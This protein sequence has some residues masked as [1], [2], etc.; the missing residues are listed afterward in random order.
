MISFTHLYPQ[1]RSEYESGKNIYQIA[2]IYKAWPETVRRGIHKAGGVT[3]RRPRKYFIEGTRERQLNYKYGLLFSDIEKIWRD[4]EG[5]CFW[6]EAP[7]SKN[8]LRCVVDHDN[9]KKTPN[10]KE[11][12]RGLCCSNGHCNRIAGFVEA[13][14]LS[15]NSLFFPFIKHVQKILG[16]SS[17]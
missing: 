5:K 4:Q 2:K 1:F 3:F 16:V 8:L 15:K 10:K 9:G 13:G 6:C 12:V 7:L 14:L 17:E 11:K